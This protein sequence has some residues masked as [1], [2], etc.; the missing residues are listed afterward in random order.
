MSY[1]VG[2]DFGTTF[3]AAAVHR[4]GEQ[5]VE[6]VPLGD[7]RASVPSVVFVAPDGGLV[8]GDAAARR[9]VT[10]PDRVVREVKRRIGDGTPLVVAGRPIEAHTIA[11][12]FVRWVVDRISEREGATPEGVALTHPASWG[13]HKCTLLTGALA[14][15]GIGSVRLVPE[16]AAAAFAYA[17][18]RDVP[19]G[20]AIAVYD[21][22]GG[23]FDAAVVRRL[24]DG[25][26]VLAG[27]PQGIEA[28]G[29]VDFDQAVFAHVRAA[30]GPP[31]TSLD[32][33]DPAVRSAA[34][35]L[36]RECTEA[37]EALSADTEVT[38]PV[39]L[40]GLSTRVRMVRSELER[41]VA[42]A[43]AETV[44]AMRRA[45][46]AAGLAPADLS[47]VLL[48]GGSSRIPLVAQ[49]VSAALD[50]PV[51]ADADPKAIVA[52]GAA[53]S[54]APVVLE[55][56]ASIV[57]VR[58]IVAPAAPVG[59][60]W[61]NRRGLMVGM[62]VAACLAAVVTTASTVGPD[63][64][65]GGTAAGEAN[66]S[67]LPREVVDRVPIGTP[68]RNDVDPW[69]GKP[70]EETTPP[71]PTRSDAKP[72][73]ATPEALT[74]TPTTGG[75]RDAAI[76][77]GPPVETSGGASATGVQP[78]IGDGGRTNTGSSSSSAPGPD[79][80]P[81]SA[82]SSVPPSSE[83]PVVSSEPPAESSSAPPTEGP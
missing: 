61:R 10:D 7:S 26:F 70:F 45:V 40:P 41:L 80:Q 34:A 25:G 28:L 31:W 33:D 54:I 29:G 39:M 62:G 79:P 74:P 2:I 52:T 17:A 22:G 77:G 36:R 68:N 13:R 4:D 23:T 43:V 59:S 32:F 81:V 55:P 57:P 42:P 72:A 18:T 30:V 76:A 63:L 65:P 48:T 44:E 11:A 16:P 24:A 58:A 35:A 12:C 67:N 47:A 1:R 50:R 53:L 6:L 19:P 69:T 14:A 60:R 46:A 64:L 83:P 15:Q 27:R 56:V 66:T 49:Q 51:T 20:A 8:M 9:S 38:I 5:A 73:E 75:D 3:T 78:P 71:G 37:K 21:L 82:E